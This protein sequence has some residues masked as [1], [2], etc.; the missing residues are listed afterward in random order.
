MSLLSNASMLWFGRLTCN[1]LALAVPKSP[2]LGSGQTWSNSRKIACLS[3]IK[4]SS[5]C[6]S[7]GSGGGGG[8]GSGSGSGSSSGN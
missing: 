2:I 6:S 3:K 4:S 1:K 7:S 5:S 8:S